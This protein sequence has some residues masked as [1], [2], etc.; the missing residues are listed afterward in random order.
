MLPPQ[1]RGAVSYRIRHAVTGDEAH[2][3]RFMI[4][5][6]KVEEA[7]N[8]D[9]APAQDMAESHLMFLRREVAENQGCVLVAVPEEGEDVPIAFALASVECFGGTYIRKEKRSV[10]WMHDLYVDE[11]HRGTEVLDLLFTATEAH[12]KALGI[13]R[14][15]IAHVAGNDR[16]RA[17][18]LKRG[19]VPYESILERA[20]D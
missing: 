5:L 15:V 16:A 7:L 13:D 12:F 8:T 18:Y 1:N 3:V 4:G 17:A 10:A 2:L 20:I 9:R 14:I 6:Q 11:A 19:F